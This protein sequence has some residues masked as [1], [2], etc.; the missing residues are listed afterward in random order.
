M[1]LS[2]KNWRYERPL[3]TGDDGA[4]EAS[5]Y[6]L[7]T[8]KVVHE[9]ESR[10]ESSERTEFTCLPLLISTV[11]YHWKQSEWHF[12]MRRQS[13]RRMSLQLM[14]VAALITSANRASKNDDS[15]NQGT[16]HNQ[17]KSWPLPNTLSASCGDAVSIVVLHSVALFGWTVLLRKHYAYWCWSLTLRWLMSYVYGAPILDVSRSHTATQH[18]R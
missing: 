15:K 6:I 7:C 8:Y 17:M 18:S 12:C 14:H 9:F 11:N 4:F 16:Y 5:L 13:A 3:M 2:K 10:Y 1:I